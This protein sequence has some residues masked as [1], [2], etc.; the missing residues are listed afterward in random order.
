MNSWKEWS[1]FCQKKALETRSEFGLSPFSPIDITK[2]LR[3]AN[4]NIIKEPIESHISGYFLRHEDIEL[5][6]INTK[7]SMGHQNFTAAHEFYH[8]KYDVELAAR[9]CVAGEFSV[10]T[11]SESKADLFASYL[12]APDEAIKF[13]IN[14]RKKKPFEDLKLEDVIYLEQLFGLS[15]AAMLHRLKQ[16]ELID[17]RQV[18]YFRPD[19]KKNAINLGYK[20]SLYT[21]SDEFEIISDYAFKAKLAF[22]K[23]LISIGKYEELLM[24]AG[25]VDILYGVD[26]EEE[27]QT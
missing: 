18:E 26:F 5:V 24:D 25:L 1:N 7:K 27:E 6:F 19:I 9:A 11:P 16:M 4:V 23:G 20:L 22:D 8:I 3:E 21:S 15:H 10:K 13:Q 17:Q 14:R 12:L 2:L